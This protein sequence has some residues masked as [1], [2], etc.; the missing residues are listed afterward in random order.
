MPLFRL[1]SQIDFPPAWLARTDGLLCIG[2]D[3]TPQRL[4][5]AYKNGIFPWF[6]ENEPILWWSPDPRLI[7]LPQEI[8]ISKSLRKTMRKDHFSVTFNRAFEKVIT[9][10]AQPRQ[11]EDNGTW[12]VDEMIEAYIALHH[13]GVAHSVESW[14]DGELVGG[15]YGLCIGRSFFGESMF[16]RCADASKV[17][18]VKLARH[19]EAHDFDMIDCQV[20]SPHLLRMGAKE[21]PRQSF[22][23]ILNRSINRK[24]IPDLWSSPPS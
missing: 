22:L 8:K 18:L 10:C 17:A 21:I 12:L 3:L 19:L 11:E 24:M 23:E 6:S 4:V 15:L 7:L 5:L 1:S 9:A 20:S 14:V 2:G 13:M 16:S